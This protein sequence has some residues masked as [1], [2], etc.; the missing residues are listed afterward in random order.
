MVWLPQ[1]GQVIAKIPARKGNR[2]WLHRDVRIRSPRLDGDRWVLPRNCL[3]RLVTA[4]VDRYGHIVVCRDMSRLSR[5]NRA[6]LEAT[7]ADCDCSCLGAHHGVD[8]TGW[9]ERAGD[10][11]VADLGAIKR[12]TVVYG[13]KTDDAE[14]VIYRGELGGRRYRPDPGGRS[15]WPAAARFVCACCLSAR[16]RVWDHCHTHGYVRAP[17]C[18][19]CNTRHWGGWQPQYGRAAPSS[20]LDTSYYQWCP[21]FGYAWE[22][23]CSA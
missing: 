19:A 3:T 18:N 2:R 12:S 16:A 14:P 5:C 10:V 1:D 4:A 6:C 15:G 21:C 7:G 8:S 9:F 17:L 23:P 22:A 20:N 11:M 13:A